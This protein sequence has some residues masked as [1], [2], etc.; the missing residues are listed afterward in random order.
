MDISLQNVGK[1]FETNWIFRNI[2]QEFKEAGK[3]AVLGPNGSG[4]STLLKAVSGNLTITEGKVSYSLN[5]KPVTVEDIYSYLTIAA[6]YLDLPEEYNLEELI[7]FHKTFKRI[8]LTAKEIITKLELG[9]TRDRLYKRFSSGMKQ[10]VKLG[11]AIMSD[12]PLLLLDEPC[13]ALDANAIKW[14]QSLISDYS[15]HKTILVFS[16][17]K[18]EEY[19]FCNSIIQLTK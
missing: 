5:N 17:H 14:Y 11:L 6:P 18:E 7:T 8:S 19:K 3:Y 16:N 4:K 12:A 15:S 2:S 13:T 9:H 10:R 1:R